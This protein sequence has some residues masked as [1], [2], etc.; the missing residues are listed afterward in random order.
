MFYKYPV[1]VLADTPSVLA[2]WAINTFD[3]TFISNL[4]RKRLLLRTPSPVPFG[5]CICSNVETILS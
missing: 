5:T 2:F 1:D 3:Q 4:I